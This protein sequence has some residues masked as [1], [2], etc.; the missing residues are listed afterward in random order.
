MT[1]ESRVNIEP[2]REEKRIVPVL[3]AYILRHGQTEA[4]K[5]KADRGLTP[6]GIRQIED[7]VL[8]LLKELDPNRDIIQFFDSGNDRV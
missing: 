6:E 8:L 2:P 5:S 3:T 7:S 1:I 4:D